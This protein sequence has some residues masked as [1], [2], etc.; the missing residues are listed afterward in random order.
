MSPEFKLYIATR[1]PNPDFPPSVTT[2]AAAV[3]FAVREGGLEG[4]LL[5][6]V[7]RHERPDLDAARGELVVKVGGLGGVGGQQGSCHHSACHM[8]M[9]AREGSPG[10]Q[11]GRH[12]C[13]GREGWASPCMCTPATQLTS[14]RGLSSTSAPAAA[15]PLW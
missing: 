9:H 10:C 7:V 11:P 1:L 15:A 2:R 13:P 4:Q 8:H 12:L 3:D 5:A 6:E 14:A